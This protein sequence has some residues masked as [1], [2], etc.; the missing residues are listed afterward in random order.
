MGGATTTR[1]YL[2]CWLV[3]HC[4]NVPQNPVPCVHS[5]NYDVDDLQ[6]TTVEI[7]RRSPIC[8]IFKAYDR[9]QSR[10]WRA[11]PDQ[12][13]PLDPDNEGQAPPLVPV[14]RRCCRSQRRWPPIGCDYGN[15]VHRCD[16]QLGLHDGT[17]PLATLQVDIP[18][19]R[20]L[21][22]RRS[23]I[24]LAWPIPKIACAKRIR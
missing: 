15:A 19:A 16:P 1:E 3:I 18:I 6:R 22:L 11:H 9:L 21:V 10:Y 20:Q 2:V 5:D 4:R 12:I 8:R 7:A 13:T 14:W 24:G 23:D 17:V